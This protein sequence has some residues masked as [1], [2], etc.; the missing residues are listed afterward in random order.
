MR[1]LD[2]LDKRTQLAIMKS[3]PEI[4]R[5]DYNKPAEMVSG[6]GQHVLDVQSQNVCVITIKSI[7]VLT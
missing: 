7:F 6:G 5:Q 2:R 3:I 4:V 1:L